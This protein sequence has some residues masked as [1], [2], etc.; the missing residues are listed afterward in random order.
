MDDAAERLRAAAAAAA[1]AAEL[2]PV[3]RTR[4]L[5]YVALAMLIQCLWGLYGEPRC[6]GEQGGAAG[7]AAR[8]RPPA[9]HRCRRPHSPPRAPPAG[10]C[11]RYLQTESSQTVPTLQLAVV[12][13]VV[14]GAG[15]VL[16]IAVP[17]WVLALYSA[18]AVRRASHP[19]AAQQ[20]GKGGVQ[21]PQADGESGKLPPLADAESGKSSLQAAESGQV[22]PQL[23]QAVP[24]VGRTSSCAQAS[25]HMLAA[26]MLRSTSS[27]ISPAKLQARPSVL[28]RAS[29]AAERA[30]E[31]RRAWLVSY[32]TAAVIGSLVAFQA[33]TLVRGMLML[34]CS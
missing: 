30:K 13:T 7:P 21:P 18:A 15:L 31:R 17:T 4:Y 1:A 10:V 5:A 3:S 23:Q 6:H 9:A 16:F 14:A 33:L 2:K 26:L 22:V 24:A 34:E 27:Y 11:T 32:G 25:D 8:A 28:Q 20:A 19:A 12:L 29:T